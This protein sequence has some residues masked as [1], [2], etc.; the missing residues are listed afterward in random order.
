MKKTAKRIVTTLLAGL[1]A[2][3]A[4]SQT[5]SVKVEFSQE[6]VT[7][8]NKIEE[9]LCDVLTR[10]EKSEK[11]LWKFNLIGTFLGGFNIAYEIKIIPKW[12]CNIQ[13]ITDFSKQYRLSSLGILT[14]L[15]RNAVFEQDL[16][17]QLR[18]Y[19]NSG[20]RIRLGKK[21]GFSGNYFGLALNNQYTFSRNNPWEYIGNADSFIYDIR[22]DWITHSNSFLNSLNFIYGIQRK[23]GRVGYIDGSL[24]L[25]LKVENVIFIHKNYHGQYSSKHSSLGFAFQP[26]L[27]IG[28]AF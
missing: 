9:A 22:M 7:T 26:R 11:D 14:S 19:Y 28:I 4:Y 18:Y 16:N 25:G 8:A 23:I 13:S 21:S 24:G 17:F 27:G 6:K 20:R 5:D 15:N 10:R 12:S 2:F 1:P 3:A